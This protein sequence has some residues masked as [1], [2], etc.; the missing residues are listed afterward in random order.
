MECMASPDSPIHA[1]TLHAAGENAA[2]AWWPFF[3][4][5]SA[6]EATN[7]FGRDS[8]HKFELAWQPWDLAADGNNVG[9]VLEEAAPR[10]VNREHCA[11][12]PGPIDGEG[13]RFAPFVAQPFFPIASEDII[14][15]L[16]Q[17][18]PWVAVGGHRKSDES[19]WGECNHHDS[20]DACCVVAKAAHLRRRQARQVPRPWG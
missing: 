12:T 7:V 16:A 1:V 13:H 20:K 11:G 14:R 9:K 5:A 18:C 15:A 17:L 10:W 19:I 4:D 8:L 6:F 3:L 2:L